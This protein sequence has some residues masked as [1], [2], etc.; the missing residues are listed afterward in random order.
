MIIGCRTI[1]EYFIKKWMLNNGFVVT[2]FSIDVKE[3]VGIIT[4]RIGDSIAVT[5]NPET[6]EVKMSNEFR[7]S[8]S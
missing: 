6:K 3:N 7:N 5:Y 4:D 8:N 1:S 2:E